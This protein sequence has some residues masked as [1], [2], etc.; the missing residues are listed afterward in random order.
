MYELPS[1]L[2]RDALLQTPFYSCS[3][4]TFENCRR[5]RRPI[6][7]RRATPPTQRHRPAQLAFLGHCSIDDPRVMLQ[8]ISALEFTSYKVKVP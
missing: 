3:M 6:P 2:E 5:T 4:K 1:E 8:S 7:H